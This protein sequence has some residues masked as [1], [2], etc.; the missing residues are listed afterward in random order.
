MKPP[1]VTDRWQV[2][3]DWSFSKNCFCRWSCVLLHLLL[4]AGWEDFNGSQEKDVRAGQI[5]LSARHSALVL[6]PLRVSSPAWPA[7]LPTFRKLPDVKPFTTSLLGISM[8]PWCLSVS[9]ASWFYSLLLIH[10]RP[11]TSAKGHPW[12]VDPGPRPHELGIQV[13]AP[14]TECTLRP[15]GEHFLKYIL[16]LPQSNEMGFL[17]GMT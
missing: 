10:Q 7:Y 14:R 2:N 12:A 11:S 5:V 15:P 13:G 9:W 17:T 1:P 6:W 16:A 4:F 3:S 8:N